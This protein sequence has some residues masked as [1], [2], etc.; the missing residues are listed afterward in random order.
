MKIRRLYREPDDFEIH[1]LRFVCTAWA[2]PEQ[3]DV[4][5]GDEQIGYV[6]LRHGVLRVERPSAFGEL[7][8]EQAFRKRLL[9]RDGGQF[10]T[11]RQ[12]YE[13]LQR[14][15]LELLNSCGETGPEARLD[16]D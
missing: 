11:A 1:G 3:Y 6:R 15:A 8:L 13:W 10:N 16:G 7:V 9:A 5:K 14:T 2:C 4:Y 12:R